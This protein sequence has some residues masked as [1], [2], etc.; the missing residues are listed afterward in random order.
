MPKG[1]QT[2]YDDELSEEE[3]KLLNEGM[4]NDGLPPPD[5]S[6]GAPADDGAAP[7]PPPAAPT[8]PPPPAA[9]PAA[10]PAAEEGAQDDGMAEFLA[11]HAGKTPE[12]L[13]K[14]AFQQSQRAGKAEIGQRQTQ[15]QIDDIRRRAQEVLTQRKASIAQRREEFKTRLEE[16]PDGA[17]LALHE[18]LLNSEEQ[19]A[20]NE[21]HIARIDSAIEL[22]STA[23]PNFTTRY[24]DIMAFGEELNYTPDEIR[25]IDDGRNIVTLYLASIAGNLIKTGVMD[26]AGN[27]RSMPTPTAETD[28]RLKMPA[29]PMT[30]LSTAGAPS[31]ATDDT[32]TVLANL[33]NMSDAEFDKLSDA[34]LELVLQRGS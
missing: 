12:E 2:A 21:A 6:E 10:A 16:D 15:E 7:P 11:K 3:L 34:E 13:L 4:E 29:N 5:E 24:K 33:L 26:A 32:A 9:Q 30:T 19:A 22:A 8:P 28:P 1:T 31:G 18:Q 23:I 17:T 25:S 20:E 14:I 27:F